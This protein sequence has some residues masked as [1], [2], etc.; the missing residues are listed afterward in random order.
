[1]LYRLMLVTGVRIGEALRLNVGDAQQAKTDL[2]WSKD[3][4]R[5]G[6]KRERMKTVYAHGGDKTFAE[7]RERET[8]A[9]VSGALGRGDNVEVLRGCV[10][11]GFGA[12][13]GDDERGGDGR[14]VVSV[15]SDGKVKLLRHYWGGWWRVASTEDIRKRRFKLLRHSNTESSLGVIRQFDSITL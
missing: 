14:G 13:G 6:E 5:K 8:G 12:G 2:M 7:D 1:M 9:E 3:G 15:E 4:T 10:S 11:G